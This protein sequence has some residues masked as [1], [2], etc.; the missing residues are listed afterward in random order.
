MTLNGMYADKIFKFRLNNILNS[1]NF[2]AS[3]GK[4]QTKN[5]TIFR[6]HKD[7]Y[8]SHKIWQR[9]DLF[10]GQTFFFSQY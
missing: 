4:Q 9:I 5:L 2:L 6:H 7:T 8:S 1:F 3:S 10:Y